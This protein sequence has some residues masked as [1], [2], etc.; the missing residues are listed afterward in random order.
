[1]KPEEFSPKVKKPKE[2]T[3]IYVS[4][5]LR[6]EMLTTTLKRPVLWSLNS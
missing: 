2:E 4:P 6:K 1:M 5:A 3:T